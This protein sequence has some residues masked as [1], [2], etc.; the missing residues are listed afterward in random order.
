MSTR[1]ATSSE[2][3]HT[4]CSSPWWVTFTL[5]PASAHRCRTAPG[6]VGVGK[7]GPP[8]RH[9]NMPNRRDNRA[10]PATPTNA[11]REAVWGMAPGTGSM[12]SKGNL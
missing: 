9:V 6:R 5:P 1:R 7:T 2:E 3:R 11:S 4:R 8:C 12:N 10:K